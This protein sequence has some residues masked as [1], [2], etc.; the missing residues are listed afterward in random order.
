MKPSIHLDINHI[1]TDLN[2]TGAF[3]L[4]A[5]VYVPSGVLYGHNC[6]AGTCWL[7]VTRVS[8]LVS[9]PS[10]ASN[11]AYPSGKVVLT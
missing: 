7:G 6:P 2:P 11:Y 1:C 4:L 5:T 8:F 3:K 10:F 9:I